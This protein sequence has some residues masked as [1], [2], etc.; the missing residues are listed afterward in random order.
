QVNAEGRIA[1]DAVAIGGQV[2][3]E[4]GGRVAGNRQSLPRMVVPFV[5]TLSSPQ[6]ALTFRFIIEALSALLFLLVLF[7]AVHF[8]VPALAAIAS[9]ATRKC[10][11]SGEAVQGFRWKV[12]TAGVRG[13]ISL[14]EMKW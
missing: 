7:L 5:G 12:T 3:I 11:Y 13:V 10:A 6:S 14:A 4:D 2:S 9:A 1:G 8:G